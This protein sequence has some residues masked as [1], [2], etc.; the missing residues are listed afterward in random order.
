MNFTKFNLASL[1]TFVVPTLI[2]ITILLIVPFAFVPLLNNVKETNKK[3]QSEQERL[4]SLANKLK[5]LNA[6]DE[7]DIN[8][9]LAKTEQVLPVGKSLA[10][11]VVGIQNLAVGNKLSVES[12]TLNPGSVATDSATTTNDNSGASASD[13]SRVREQSNNI[14]VLELSLR[15]TVSSVQK[16]LSQIQTAKRL[17]FTNEVS[18]DSS[19]ES[20]NYAIK[21]F[22]DTPFKPVAKSEG[23]FVSQPLP[24]LSEKDLETLNLV[25][26][27][28]NV[29]N[30]KITEV[31]TGVKDPFSGN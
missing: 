3:L 22:L 13:N 21:L 24:V 15:G 5:I 30:I 11:L 4:D 2:L 14:L 29:T 26:R 1:K 25:D 19:E 23:D 10:S 7:S 28:I 31:Q 18:L 17:M 6:L 8:D 20:R 27:F 9:K 16:F 12:I